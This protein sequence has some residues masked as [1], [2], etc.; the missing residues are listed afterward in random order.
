MVTEHFSVMLVIKIIRGYR[1]NR[2]YTVK[3]CHYMHHLYNHTAYNF[4]KIWWKL[5]ADSDMSKED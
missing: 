5:H 3:H 2:S 4:V 1:L